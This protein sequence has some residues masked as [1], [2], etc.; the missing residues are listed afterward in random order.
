MS[1]ILVN[2]FYWLFAVLWFVALVLFVVNRRHVKGHWIVFTLFVCAGGMAGYL[3]L[4]SDVMQLYLQSALQAHSATSTTRIGLAAVSAFV[5]LA[6]GAWWLP[7]EIHNGLQK[8]EAILRRVNYDALTGLPNRNLAIDRLDEAVMRAQVEGHKM[9]VMFFDL[10]T[11]KKVNDSFGTKV[12]DDLL[13]QTAIRLKKISGQLNTVARVGS[14][15]FLIVLPKIK[16]TLAVEKLAMRMNAA[17][18]EPFNLNGK[19]VTVTGSLGISIY[20]TDGE[21]SSVLIQHAASALHKAKSDGQK[22][23]FH[24]YTEDIHNQALER[25]KIE[26]ELRLALERNELQVFYQPIIDTR[27]KSLV[28]AEALLRWT[29]EKLGFVSPADFIPVAEDIGMIVPIGEWVL[30]Q[31]YAQMQE[32][33]NDPDAP[34]YVTV[35][36]SARQFRDV[37]FVQRVKDIIF[38]GNLNPCHIKLEVTESLLVGDVDNVESMMNEL[39]HVGLRLSLDDFGTGYSSLSYL[40][41]YDFDTLK[42]D[43]S[44][45]N[46]IPDD[47]GDCALV[48]A[49]LALSDSLG[50]EV[51]AEGVETQEQLNYLSKRKCQRVQGFFFSKPLPAPEFNDFILSWVKEKK[52]K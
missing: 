27:T 47:Q 45:I 16:S 13:K 36:V 20:P 15:E 11:F 43:R 14:D 8:E 35:N 2:I 41:R 40:K 34:D 4:T 33:V 51:V 9:A 29:N 30:A 44:F 28:G 5:V 7:R 17:F 25:L 3:L 12:G 18:N 22:G 39:K 42:I 37:D 50:L 49:I 6:L 26:E 38:S 31:A 19:E 48:D 32:W 46:D 24:F 52:A 1:Q 10:D 23:S 21:E